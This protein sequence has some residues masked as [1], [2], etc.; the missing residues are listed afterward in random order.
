MPKNSGDRQFEAD[1]R[2]TAAKIRLKAEDSP[3]NAD[4]MPPTGNKLEKYTKKS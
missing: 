4:K 1:T 3:V 2:S